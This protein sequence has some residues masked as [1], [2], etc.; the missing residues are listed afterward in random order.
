MTAVFE[1]LALHPVIVLFLLIGLG[2][3]LGQVRVGG[4][5]LGAVAVLLVGMAIT[6]WGVALGVS[7]ELPA[8]IGDVG[9]VLFAFCIGIISGPGFFNAMKSSWALMLVVTGILIVGAAAAFG[10]GV[11]FGVSPVTIAGTF[12]G[13]V[14]NTPALAATGGSAEATVGYAS[15]YIF[16]VIGAL[17]VAALALRHRAA[18]TDAPAPIIDKAVEIDTTSMPTADELSKRHG[19]R[20]LFSRVMPKDGEIEAVGPDT[21]LTP[22]AVVNVV[23]PSDAVEAVSDEIGHTAAVDIV[24]QRSELD[25]RRIILSNPRLAGRTVASLQLRERLGATIVRVRRG[26]VEFVATPDFVVL[27]GDR[28]RVVGPKRSMPAV[29]E[30]LGDSERGMADTNPVALGLGI[31]L[32]LLIGAIQIPLPGGGYFGL[33]FGAGAL[34]VGLIMG[35]IGRIGP[36][37]TSLPN[38]AANVLAEL[39]LLIFLAFAGTKA[40]SLI[41]SAIVSGE[42]VTLLLIGAVV[43][44]TVMLGTYLMLRHVFRLG[45]T[46]LSGAIAGTQTNPAILAFANSRTGHDV[47]VALGY[48]LVY[49]A[50][51]VVKILLAQVLVTL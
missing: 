4:V 36:F 19:R 25:F 24:G 38:T 7:I 6:A 34:V 11:A 12:A 2:A 44:L 46:R 15:A 18:D 26:D 14:T 31:A 17:V 41:V 40:G 51:M 45:G 20:V 43:T 49:P 5:S 42:I 3:A 39:G 9:L 35:R 13:A 10:L 47:R 30:F 28:L 48:R 21:Q 16:G 33:G 8:A 29:S 50:A 1:F 32:G 37:V 27:Q 23:G 22:G